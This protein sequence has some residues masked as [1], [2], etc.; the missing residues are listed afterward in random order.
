MRNMDTETQTPCGRCE[1]RESSC[2]DWVSPTWRLTLVVEW[3]TMEEGSQKKMRIMAQIRWKRVASWF[4]ADI[5]M[6]EEALQ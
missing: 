1:N 4:Q 5:N 6:A 2:Y 3:R